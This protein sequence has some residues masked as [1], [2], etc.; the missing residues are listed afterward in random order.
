MKS[1]YSFV[2]YFNLVILAMIH[3]P[4]IKRELEIPTF[5][6]I[7]SP[8]QFYRHDDGIREIYP[9]DSAI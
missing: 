1:Q 8:S 5:I 6:I 7:E 3:T 4:P 2:L 9:K